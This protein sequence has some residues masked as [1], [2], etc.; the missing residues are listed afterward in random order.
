MNLRL[1]SNLLLAIASSCKGTSFYLKKYF[2][3]AVLLPSDWIMIA[4]LFLTVNKTLPTGSLPAALRRV[5]KEKFPDFDEHQLAKYNKSLKGPSMD[6]VEMEDREE[7]MRGR[8]YDLKRLVRLLHIKDPADIV[9]AI[10]EKKYPEDKEKFRQSRLDGMFDPSRA[11]KR[12]KLKTPITWE[13]QISLHGNKPEVWANLIDEKKLPYMATVRNIRNLLLSG[14]SEAH[15]K[16]VCSY[17]S[18]QTAV[19]RSRMFPFQFFTAYDI[20]SEVRQIKEEADGGGKKRQARKRPA[21]GGD[22]KEEKEKWMISKEKKRN[23]LIKGIN[24][25]HIDSIKLALD[26]AVNISARKNIPPLK[27]TTLILCGYSN[28]MNRR[29]TEAK[30]VSQKGATVR[31]VTA[32]FSLMC[33]QACEDSQLVFFSANHM[34]L[35]LPGNEILSKVEFVKTHSELNKKVGILNSYRGALTVL[36]DYLENEKFV[37][38]LIIFQDQDNNYSPL[39][40]L[41]KK[42]RKYVNK[43][44]LLAMVNICGRPADSSE[45]DELFTH[46]NDLNI[47]GFSDS[48]FNMIVNKGNGGQLEAVEN[49]DKK[50]NL[51]N[52]RNPLLQ[53]FLGSEEASPG[54]EIPVWQHVRVFVSSTFLDMEAERN[55]LH[56]FVLPQ[57]QRKAAQRYINVD[58]IDLRWGLD[59]EQLRTNNEVELCLDQIKRCDL[60]IGILGER[61]GW[62]PDTSVLDNVSEEYRPVLQNSVGRSITEIEMRF[63]VLNCP[64][65]VRDRSFFYFRATDV[66]AELGPSF[67]CEERDDIVKL[68]QLKRTIRDSGVEVKSY[69]CSVQNGR[70]TGL[71]EFGSGVLNNL[72]NALDN[73]YPCVS[74]T[75]SGK[76]E[77]ELKRQKAACSRT[78]GEFSGRTKLLETVLQEVTSKST[79]VI[80]LRGQAG[81][82]MTSVL[83]TAAARLAN[84]KGLLIIPFISHTEEQV[85]TNYVLKYVIHHL[86]GK[87]TDENSIKS[88]SVLLQRSL[89]RFSLTSRRVVIFLDSL[90]KSSQDDLCWFPQHI[91]ENCL[92]VVKALQGSKLSVL[93]KKQK[94]NQDILVNKLDV[95]ERNEICREVLKR[96]GK[97]LGETAFNNQLLS[98]VGKRGAG[99]PG[100]LRQALNQI[101]KQ[102][103][104]ANL[105]EEISKLGSTIA[106][107]NNDILLD[108]EQIFG[109]DFVKLVMVF[110]H[111]SVVGLTKTQITT[112]CSFYHH[113]LN[114]N[115]KPNNLEKLVEEFN[116]FRTTNSN[117]VSL[118]DVSMCMERLEPCLQNTEETLQILENISSV[119]HDRY[120][121]KFKSSLLMEINAILATVHIDNYMKEVLTPSG[122]SSLTHHIGVCGDIRLLKTIV[123]S[124]K[125]IQVKS[126]LGQGSQLYKE[127]LGKSLKF[128]SAQEKFSKDPLVREYQAFVKNNLETIKQQPNL[129]SQVILNE[130]EDSVIKNSVSSQNIAITT[131]RW[132]NGP[133]TVKAAGFGG[134]TIISNASNPTTFILPLDKIV[135]TGYSDGSLLV[136]SAESLE[137]MFCLV[138]HSQSITGLGELDKT[139]LV[140]ASSDGLLSTWDMERRIRLN[141]VK[142]HDRRLSSL[143]VRS[144]HILTASWDGS[145]KVWSKSLVN[146]STIST[147][148]PLNCLLLHPTKLSVIT[149]GWDANIRIW[150]LET[151]KQKAVIRGHDSSVQSIRLSSDCRKIISGN[152]K[153]LK[154]E[155]ESNH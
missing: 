20:L 28:D 52:L 120:I 19:A 112:V 55:I 60:F 16:K 109:F 76:F 105:R 36:K 95:Q 10:L 145:V 100:Y 141:S 4:N 78:A 81:S 9:L 136:S 15:V 117:Y 113:F 26:E 85:D 6:G 14:I 114:K 131:L 107:I 73:L 129:I 62:V 70:I 59:P 44:L 144:P 146:I 94:D 121:K 149:G 1:I 97:S 61:Y 130:P 40:D 31:D 104:F 152:T 71:E 103:N 11:G 99:S 64:D 125:F 101:S 43:N 80:S 17:I 150:D 133:K 89:E 154:H 110:L 29:F 8:D 5:M 111:E 12:M 13:T 66:S 132:N 7:I 72:C 137:E 21:A 47:R 45:F 126:S 124:P 82:G 92:F 93:L 98:L 116:V 69:S 27:G 35:T 91:P 106:E 65:D 49:I 87:A 102:A 58:F 122:V 30:G 79:G 135:L 127:Y 96:R 3:A 42:Y 75:E 83:A 33:Q 38:N 147:K 39:Y 118:I 128:K 77:E 23:E 50:Y 53:T 148:S 153:S 142:A 123:C 34:E 86:G 46:Q 57:L 32:L 68:D 138:G 134:Q 48:V 139:V 54:L 63:G 67:E 25:K 115:L 143:A 151:L 88:L 56:Q 24:L 108:C 140:S 90:E 37:D 22:Q 84:T 74:I 155:I 18:N 51:I 119:V 41:V 2:S